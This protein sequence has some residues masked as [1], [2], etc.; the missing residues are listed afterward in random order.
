MNQMSLDA[1]G[2]IWPPGAPALRCHAGRAL[3]PTV[4]RSRE[5]ALEHLLDGQ[6]FAGVRPVQGSQRGWHRA[7]ADP[8]QG[9]HQELQGRW[10]MRMPGRCSTVQG[11]QALA[12]DSRGGDPRCVTQARTA[13]PRHRCHRAEGAVGGRTAQVAA[14][15]RAHPYAAAPQQGRALCAACS[16][17]A[18][19][20]QTVLGDRTGHCSDLVAVGR[21]MPQPS[22]RRCSP[23]HSSPSTHDDRSI[24]TVAACGGHVG[25]LW[26]N[27]AGADRP[28]CNDRND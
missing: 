2:S 13:A 1:G 9:G 3:S 6:P 20:A 19:L 4:G 25:G 5:R 17:A 22:G 7:Q 28:I 27:L 10:A 16:A 21:C 11:A 14:A 18:A 23:T 26:M 8:R 24:A 15:R 12:H